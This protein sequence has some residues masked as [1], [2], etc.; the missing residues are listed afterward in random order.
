MTVVKPGT[1]TRYFTHVDD[2]VK[3]IIL[4][5]EKGSGDGYMLGSKQPISINDI[6]KMFDTQFVYI[7]ERK[8]ERNTS[9]LNSNKEYE[10]G[11]EAHK[12]L[13]DNIL[14]IKNKIK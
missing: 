6:V 7:D 1:Q 13:E 5:T 10:L 3:G 8:G 11:W 12:K 9:I 14:E 4:V 2:I